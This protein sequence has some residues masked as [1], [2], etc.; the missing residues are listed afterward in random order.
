MTKLLIYSIITMI[1]II[2]FL[3]IVSKKFNKESKDVL[4][5]VSA[6]LTVALHFSS[7]WVDFFATG[8]AIVENTMLLPIYPCNIC[9]WLLL[10]VAFN[11]NKESKICKVLCEFL[12]LGGTVCGLI[13]LFANEIFLSNPDFFN[14]DSLKGLLSHSTMLLGTLI[15]LTQGYCTVRTLDMTF[16]CTIGLLIF[17]AIG[18]AINL[19]YYIFNLEPVNSMYMLEFPLDSPGVS[20]LTMGVLAIIIVFI[21]TSIYEIIFVEASE[22]WYHKIR[23]H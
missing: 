9:M 22:R 10:I 4:L 1:I 15:I 21:L 3:V 6:V 5:K 19:L 7:L 16:S 13:G 12:G 14:Y 20:F 23:R 18:G 8:E 2:I 11:K 17:V